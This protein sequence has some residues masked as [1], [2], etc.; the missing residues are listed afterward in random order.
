MAWSDRK[1][2]RRDGRTRPTGFPGKLIPLISASDSVLLSKYSPCFSMQFF[3]WQQFVRNYGGKVG[4][5]GPRPPQAFGSA[6]QCLLLLL[7]K[8]RDGRADSY[9]TSST[10]LPNTLQYSC[11][12][13]QS[14]S[15]LVW[16]SYPLMTA[17]YEK[18]HQQLI[19]SRRI[20][21]ESADLSHSTTAVKLT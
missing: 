15:E 20:W 17:S 19:Y 14:L 7:R 6:G 9:V 5:G 10:I 12:S 1:L 2:R 13:N 21:Q 8:S 4:M 18:C 3:I 16:Y 11:S